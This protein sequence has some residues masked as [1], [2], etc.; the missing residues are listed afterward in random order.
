MIHYELKEEFRLALDE[1]VRELIRDFRRSLGIGF[2][3]E[4]A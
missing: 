4:R 1:N 3:R 2:L